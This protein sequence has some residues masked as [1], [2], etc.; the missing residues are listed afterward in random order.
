MTSPR[1][2]ALIA[3]VRVVGAVEEHDL[4]LSEEVVQLYADGKDCGEYRN[5]DTA[6]YQRI[7]DCGRAALVTCESGCKGLSLLL[8]WGPSLKRAG[9][10]AHLLPERPYHRLKLPG[11]PAVGEL[12]VD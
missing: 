6:D 7:L 1:R 3:C 9:I 12:V 2:Q 10:I 5:G 4:D 8:H 11:R